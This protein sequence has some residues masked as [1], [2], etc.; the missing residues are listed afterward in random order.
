MEQQ[1]TT[2]PNQI[3]ARPA[4]LHAVVTVTR[5]ATGAV[6]E[7]TITGTAEPATHETQQKE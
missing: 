4:V 5:K 7:Y 3:G 2:E 1:Q 6:E